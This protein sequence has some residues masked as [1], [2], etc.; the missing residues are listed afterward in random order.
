MPLD[1]FILLVGTHSRR[2]LK[3]MGLQF[4]KFLEK[5]RKNGAKGKMMKTHFRQMVVI[6]E[7]VGMHFQVH[8]G[9]KWVDV[10][11]T[12]EMLGRRLGEFSHTCKL[13]K[14]SGPGI[15]ATRGSKSVEL[16]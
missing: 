9:N 15:G 1:Q 11:P 3:R 5:M 10:K 16:K 8:N 7:M 13:V 2:A 4:K 12:P 6:P 14:Q